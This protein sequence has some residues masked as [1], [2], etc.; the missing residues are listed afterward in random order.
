MEE[1]IEVESGSHIATV[2][3]PTDSNQWIFVCHG[4]GGHKERQ[5]DILE[6]ANREGF[7]AVGLD[8]RGNGESSGDF[9]EQTLTSRIKDLEA[10]VRH[11]DPERFALYGTS[12]G[13]KVVFHSL[14]E[15][16][17]EA[18]VVKAPVTYNETM[19]KFRSVVEE[20]GSYEYI[21][22]KPIDDRF[23]ED[24][25]SYSFDDLEEAVDA[26]VAIFHGADD[27]TVH[28]KHSFRAAE[29]LDTDVMLQKYRGEEHSFT[30]EGK[31]KMLRQM[32]DWLG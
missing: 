24:L 26:P 13:A 16:E 2:H 28:P 19:D 8:F 17:P 5:E 22:G 20:K 25:Y 32:F 27:T 7:N 23:I 11:F 18:V 14:K 29:A 6:R 31:Q 10:V 1:K 3:Y 9:F 30:E 15:L 12:F 4:F 21:E